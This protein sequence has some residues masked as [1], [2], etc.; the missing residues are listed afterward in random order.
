M[1][2]CP[3]TAATGT[4]E[5]DVSG[6]E[7]IEIEGGKRESGWGVLRD[8]AARLRGEEDRGRA[9]EGVKKLLLYCP[10]ANERRRRVSGERGGAEASGRSESLAERQ[11]G[12]GPRGS[13]LR[14]LESCSVAA[15][16]LEILLYKVPPAPSV[17]RY[18]H[19]ISNQLSPAP[20]CLTLTS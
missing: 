9:A 19:S 4:A 13:C 16:A 8:C 18:T 10:T 2:G 17:L 11:L 14:N 7:A 12:G 5:D 1:D 6:A 3:G 20:S 15:G